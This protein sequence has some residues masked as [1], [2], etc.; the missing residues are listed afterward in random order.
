MNPL[1]DSTAGK[2]AL[3]TDPVFL[4]KVSAGKP[5]AE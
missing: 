4:K 2:Q 3:L 1:R 5:A